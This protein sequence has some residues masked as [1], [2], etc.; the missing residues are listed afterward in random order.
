ME[1]DTWYAKAVAWA[2]KNA[3]VDGIGGGH[4]DPEANVSR[5]QLATILFRYAKTLGLDTEAK[6]DFAGFEDGDKVSSWAADAMSWA[7]AEGI[8]AGSKDGGKLYLDPQGNAT[9]AQIA[10]MLMRFLQNEE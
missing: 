7:V 9:R 3:I 6:A 5:E 1:D 2:A 10:L 8:I 4:F